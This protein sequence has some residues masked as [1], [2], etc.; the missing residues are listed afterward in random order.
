MSNSFATKSG[1][2]VTG[3]V[4]MAV[5]D[6]GLAEP[7]TAETPIGTVRVDGAVH[8]DNQPFTLEQ[9]C[10][11]LAAICALQSGKTMTEAEH[12]AK[13]VFAFASGAPVEAQEDTP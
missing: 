4:A 11:A 5:G 9:L 3:A 1:S 2:H 7:V 12:V 10:R 13:V 6:D 8:V